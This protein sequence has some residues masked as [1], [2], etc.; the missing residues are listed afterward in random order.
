MWLDYPCVPRAP[1]IEQVLNAL[2]WRLGEW[3]DNR[4]SY[5]QVGRWVLGGWVSRCVGGWVDVGGMGDVGVGGWIL[6]LAPAL[7]KSRVGS[8]EARPFSPICLVLLLD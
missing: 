6:E 2:L 1:S 8:E 7:L 5:K 4:C 3:V